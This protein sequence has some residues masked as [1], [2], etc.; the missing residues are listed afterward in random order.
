MCSFCIL[1]IE[2]KAWSAIC[3]LIQINLIFIYY[4]VKS[5]VCLKK[6]KKMPTFKIKRSL[7]CTFKYPSW[8][9]FC[10]PSLDCTS[11]LQLLKLQNCVI[12][13]RGEGKV[14]NIRILY[15]YQEEEKKKWPTSE[16]C[17]GIKKRRRKSDQ[18]QTIVPV[19]RRGE[20]EK[21]PTSEYCSSI[22]KRE[23]G[24][25]TN[26]RLLFCYQEE[27]RRK[28]DQHQNIVPV[29]RKGIKKSD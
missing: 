20:K 2:F 24:K 25:V 11:N 14:T 10:S 15:W 28:S 5:V 4:S 22:K 12:K 9:N 23:E 29:S 27:G 8:A 1:N 17:S 7:L 16:Y 21:W 13:R 26:I 6:Q 3:L 18:H 19:S